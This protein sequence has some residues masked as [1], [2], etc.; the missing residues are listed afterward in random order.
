MGLAVI[1]AVVK[2]RLGPLMSQTANSKKAAV[3]PFRRDLTGPR[4]PA[5]IAVEVKFRP[6]LHKT[7]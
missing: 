6:N 5:V 7:L 4:R 3:V 2:F 1:T